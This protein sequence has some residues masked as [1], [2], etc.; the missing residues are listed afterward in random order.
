MNKSELIDVLVEKTGF[1]KTDVHELID[2]FIET[3]VSCVARGDEVHLMGFGGFKSQARAAREGRNPSTGQKFVVEAM[4]VP[5][6]TPG[7]AFKSAV[8]EG[9]HVIRPIRASRST[10]KHARNRSQISSSAPAARQSVS[11]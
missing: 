4:S 10:S 3:V 9:G 2:G 1:R 7:K 6:F 8:A 5:K 11:R